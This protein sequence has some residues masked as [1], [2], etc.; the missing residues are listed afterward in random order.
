MRETYLGPIF[1]F[2]RLYADN[3]DNVDPLGKT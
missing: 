2:F 3:W 1:L